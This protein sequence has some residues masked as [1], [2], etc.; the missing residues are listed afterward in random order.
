M[1]VKIDALRESN[2]VSFENHLPDRWHAII[3]LVLLEGM[4][5]R[6]Q[7]PR[8]VSHTLKSAWTEQARL[9]IFND[10][11]IER[12]MWRSSPSIMRMGSNE[13]RAEHH[14]IV[15]MKIAG[16]DTTAKQNPAI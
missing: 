16:R 7:I 5:H 11:G 2:A 15:V 3:I 9:H 6:G 10:G 1:S 4:Q 14:A 12:N 8:I 13:R